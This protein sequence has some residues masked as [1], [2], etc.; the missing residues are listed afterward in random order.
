MIGKKN[1]QVRIWVSAK[2]IKFSSVIGL[3]LTR[4][5]KQ[6]IFFTFYITYLNNKMFCLIV[7]HTDFIRSLIA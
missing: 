7:L 3:V 6:I 2:R 4:N 1:N 5:C